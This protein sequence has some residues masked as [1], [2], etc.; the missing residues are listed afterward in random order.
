ML[1]KGWSGRRRGKRQ[2]NPQISMMACRVRVPCVGAEKLVYAASWKYSR[3]GFACAGT[4]GPDAPAKQV[5]RSGERWGGVCV[6]AIPLQT[7]GL[8]TASSPHFTSAHLSVLAA[9]QPNSCVSFKVAALSILA[10]LLNSDANQL[11]LQQRLETNVAA[12]AKRGG[13]LP[14]NKGGSASGSKVAAGAVSTQNGEG[15]MLSQSSA[16]LQE[17]WEAVLQL[18]GDVGPG[19]APSIG[20]SAIPDGGASVRRR[21]LDLMEVVVR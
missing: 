2:G 7:V 8:M 16:I 6:W 18:A 3:N 11:Q 21:A 5:L 9:L 13:K 4:V 15:D 14:G 20:S 19:P 17:H 12:G 1:D 10:D